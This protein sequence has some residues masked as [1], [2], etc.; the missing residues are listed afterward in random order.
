MKIRLSSANRGVALVVTLIMLS[1]V[2]LM[3]VTFL[4]V[5][6]RERA[7][8]STTE[9]STTARL[10]AEA[11]LARANSEVVANVLTRGSLLAY[12][13]FVSTNFY[14]PLGFDPRVSY[15]V[16]T[17]TNVNYVYRLGG[18]P[19]RTEDWLRNIANLQIA[20]RAPVFIRTND[21]VRAPLDFRFFL[22]LNR[23]GRFETNGIGP[24]LSENNRFLT[25]NLTETSNWDEVWTNYFVGDPEWVGILARPDQPHSPSNRFVGRYAY[26]V[27][28]AGKSLDLNTVHNNARTRNLSTVGY[29]RNQGVG[30]WEFNLAA[31]LHDLNPRL[32]P[33][34][35][36]TGLAPVG[37]AGVANIL[38]LDL[39]RF[40]YANN[41]NNL[42]PADWWF[43]PAR[44]AEL[45]NDRI[46]L[47]SDGSHMGG[48]GLPPGERDSLDRPWA[49]SDQPRVFTDLN[50]WY[51]PGK[52]PGALVTNLMTVSTNL[53]SLDRYTFYRAL[54][55]AGAD[56]TPTIDRKINL[57]YDNLPPFAITNLQPWQPLRFFT[58]VAQRLI[59]SARLTNIVRGTGRPRTNYL[60]GDA[61]VRPEMS[62][63]NIMIWP[64]NEYSASVHRLLQVAA[65]LFDA[66]TNRARTAGVDFP[67]V[68][69]P[70]FRTVD[71]NIFIA[72]YSEVTD[73]AFLNGL[74]PLDLNVPEDRARLAAAKTDADGMVDAVVYNVPFVIGAK[75]GL[76]NFNEFA[77]LNV[78]QVTRKAEVRKR[79]ATDATPSQT[80]LLYLLTVTN[81]FGL[82]AWNSYSNAYPRPVEMRVLGRFSVMITNYAN[83]AGSVLRALE[84][85]YATNQALNTWPGG[86]F[87]VPI[88][89]NVLMAT[90]AVY[91]PFPRPQLITNQ[92]YV[93]NLG[94]YV[95]EWA[96]YMTNRFYYA[97][98]DRTSNRLLDFVCLGN[99]ANAIDLTRE[100]AGRPAAGA[101]G[102]AGAEPANLWGTNR[103]GG[104]ANLAVPTDGV[105]NQ[106]EVS[107]GNIPVSA[108]S[109]RSYNAN[110][111][112]GDDKEKS[113]D[114]FRLF[115]GLT[116]LVYNTERDLAVLAS[117]LR[118]KLAMQVPFAPTRKLAQEVS[119]QVND[120]L[121]H[122][123]LAD[124]VDPFNPPTDPNRTNAVQVVVP[125]RQPT[126]SNLGLL[127]TRYRPWGGNP[128][129]SSDRLAYD[130]RFKDPM[131]RSSDD[132]DFPTNRLPNVGWIGRVHRGTPWQTLYLKSGYA[133]TNSWLSW[134]GS[135]GTHPT[136]DWNLVEV[137]TTA[138]NDNASRGLLGVNQTNLAAWS[139]V[140]AGVSVLSN[141]T[142]ATTVNATNVAAEE[143]FIEPNL[144][145]RPQLLSIVAGINRTRQQE[146]NLLPGGRAYPA[147]HRLGRILATPELTLASPYLNTNNLLND[148]IL[149]RIPQ[150]ILS[151]LKEDEPRF[152]VYAFGQA[153]KEAPGSLYMGPG[154]FNRLCTNYQVKAEFATKT[155]IRLEG[156]LTNPRA[157]VE[158]HHELPPP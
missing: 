117:D 150:Q 129:Q 29:Y 85:P 140:L 54:A 69:R 146:A 141:T 84:V 139:A 115:V 82:E 8:V 67:S 23:N 114:R 71:T 112:E 110:A 94:F 152:V 32:A 50:E 37:A 102:A 47:Y 155:V 142:P 36:Y 107:L 55:E 154:G 2:T 14:N 121:V 125:P 65:N 95:P 9:E 127:N 132:W 3:A 56:S 148:A 75:K 130:V 33:S 124:L 46:D 66:T 97:L 109:W 134:A 122:Y 42:A 73:T 68:F 4:A 12:D 39:L 116:P 74:V 123:T 145:N 151:L 137:F 19:L 118:G 98:V 131:V 6:R 62:L 138:F 100:L 63:T 111:A 49:G 43:N 31:F 158:S 106:M 7:A 26:I 16:A 35:T 5:S 24:M 147:F 25:T 15:N 79:A 48:I 89:R 70:R 20:P 11:A 41:Y 86:A 18:A 45:E 59:E 83:G 113:I 104:S 61:L 87:Q 119:W 64:T 13:L 156:P 60:V 38:A 101:T 40:R 136:N 27:L 77:L 81:Q 133:D 58:N 80:N 90:N 108:A 88:L 143:L 126:N 17:P 105:F 44:S 93:P 10:M 144:P 76:P 72:G 120:P 128:N 21:D 157:I 149:E 1:V 153:L 103:L 30:P 53:A 57:N 22:D 91:L 96:V 34:Y 92:A 52:T 28:P 99:M 78:A 51:A 135:R